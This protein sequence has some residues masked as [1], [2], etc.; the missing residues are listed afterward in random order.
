MCIFWTV[1]SV[2]LLLGSMHQ[3]LVPRS[4]YWASSTPCTYLSSPT[5]TSLGA[6]LTWSGLDLVVAQVCPY[7]ANFTH[8][9]WFGLCV[10]GFP[11]ITL[12]IWYLLRLCMAMCNL[13]RPHM[14]L[15]AAFNIFCPLAQYHIESFFGAYRPRRYNL[16]RAII[17]NEFPKYYT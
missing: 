12:T 10:G 14:I 1:A 16:H 2:R 15:V 13:G 11:H 17:F 5:R 4:V 6:C 9:N 8:V 7:L 3:Y